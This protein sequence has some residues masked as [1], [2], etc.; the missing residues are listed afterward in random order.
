MSDR[1]KALLARMAVHGL[2][3]SGVGTG[4]PEI[5]AQD[6]AFACSGTSV[7]GYL[8]ALSKWVHDSSVQDALY[9]HAYLAAV[10]VAAR[11]RWRV[12]KGQERVRKLSRMAIGELVNPMKCA[13]CQGR[14]EIWPR[15][16]ST[17]IACPR[18][19][20]TGSRRLRAS[21]MAR[22]IGVDDS[23]WSRSWAGKYEALYRLYA[24]WELDALK[25]IAAGLSNEVRA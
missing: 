5:T 22:V 2:D 6:V 16:T 4:G 3:Y 8:V 11:D 13:L 20:G 1:A 12:P 24:D 7:G 21:E 10:D 14:A 18:C 9:Y 17:P 25:Q 15:G 23:T 19:G